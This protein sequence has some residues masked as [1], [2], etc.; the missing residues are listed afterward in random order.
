MAA[1]AFALRFSDWCYSRITLEPIDSSDAYGQST[2]GSPIADIPCHIEEK[3]RMIRDAQ[4][5]ERA[6]TTTLYVIGGPIDPRDRI[7]M[8]GSFKG[9]SQ[10]PILSVSNVNDKAGFS[11]SEVYL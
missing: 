3:V 6:S 8:P 5:Q 10:P 1:G 2:Y 9:P 7:T 4:G 11:H